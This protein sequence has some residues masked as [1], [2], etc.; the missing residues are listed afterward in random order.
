LEE[1]ILSERPVELTLEQ[2]IEMIR[3]TKQAEHMSR[4]Q[5]RDVAIELF[6]SLL[7][8][9]TLYR[10]IF[11]NEAPNLPPLRELP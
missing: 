1:S 3:F 7:V 2:E 5:A 10:Q 9:E 4:E 6:R 11:K 8:R